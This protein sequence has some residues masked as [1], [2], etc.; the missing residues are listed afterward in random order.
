VSRH[1]EDFLPLKDLAYRLMLALA[2]GGCHGGALVQALEETD[3][4]RVL[5][6]ELYRTLDRM[7]A[8]GLL[9]ERDRPSGHCEP[10]GKRGTTPTRFFHLTSLGCQVARAETTRL[11]RLIA[12]SHQGRLLRTRR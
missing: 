5:P 8:D 7:I 4:T 2:D 6:G 11:E 1:V 10:P 12:R 3:G 9:E